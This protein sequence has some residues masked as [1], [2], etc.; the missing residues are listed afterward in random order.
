[1]RKRL[2]EMGKSSKR[3]LVTTITSLYRS[4]EFLETFLQNCLEQSLFSKTLFSFDFSNPSS[5]EIQILE[6]Y[7]PY[8]G[9]QIIV[10]RRK[11]KISIYVAWNDM[12]KN[13]TTPFLAIWNVDDLRTPDSLASQVQLM[14]DSNVRSVTGP[15]KIVRNFGST[16]GDRIDKAESPKSH[17]LEGMLHGPFFMFRKR[18]LSLLKGFDEKFLVAADF[19]FAIRLTSLGTVGYTKELLGYYLNQGKGLSTS[20]D[21]SLELERE[22]IYLRYGVLKKLDFALLPEASN[23]DFSHVTVAGENFAVVNSMKNFEEVRLGNIE[24]ATNELLLR[25]ICLQLFRASKLKT[26]QQIKQLLIKYNIHRK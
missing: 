15:F 18:D 5:I 20:R 3:Y 26:K 1:M 22:R 19:D 21:S 9:E 24:Q 2:I 12:C 13:S 11:S 25:K 4:E 8:F 14:I 16:V 10:K 7:R 6:K 17:W 23:F